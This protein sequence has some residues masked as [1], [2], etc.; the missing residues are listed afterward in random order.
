[1]SKERQADL[2]WAIGND[3]KA[4]PADRI[5]ALSDL[6]KLMGWNSERPEAPMQAVVFQ[7]LR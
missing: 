4:K 1:M 5:R 6:A 2:L 7:V 3:P